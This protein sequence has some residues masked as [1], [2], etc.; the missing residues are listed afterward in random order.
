[1]ANPERPSAEHLPQTMVY[2]RRKH[3][4]WFEEMHRQQ[5][6]EAVPENC[7]KGTKLDSGRTGA[8]ENHSAQKR[9][10]VIG[11]TPQSGEA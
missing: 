7:S 6:A 11:K 3:W 2:K 4:A 5:K 1:M 8:G 9:P 10:H